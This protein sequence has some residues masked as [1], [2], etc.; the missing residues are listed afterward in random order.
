MGKPHLDDLP[1]RARAAVIALDRPYRPGQTLRRILIGVVIVSAA[2]GGFVLLMPTEAA[3]RPVVPT[4][5][6]G[7]VFQ[8]LRVPAQPLPARAVPHESA[9]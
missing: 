2:A 4:A 3:R 6:P 7:V 5:S 8:N 1:P 9:P